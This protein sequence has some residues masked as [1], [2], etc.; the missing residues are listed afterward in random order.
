MEKKLDAAE[1]WFI[2][3]MMRISWTE[4][5]SNKSILKEI[6]TERSLIKTIRKKPG[7]DLLAILQKSLDRAIF[8]YNFIHEARL[9][10]VRAS[11]A[12]VHIRKFYKL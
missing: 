12:I 6:N 7:I 10:A 2:R 8:L 9:S 3:R 5:R 4:K 11:I 1:M